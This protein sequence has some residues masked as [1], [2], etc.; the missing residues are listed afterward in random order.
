M[1][2][3]LTHPTIRR[4]W[5]EVLNRCPSKLVPPDWM[6]ALGIAEITPQYLR[7]APAAIMHPSQFAAAE[8][9]RD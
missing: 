8:V 4:L 5:G 3:N 6:I 2:A 7:H 9:E 1:D